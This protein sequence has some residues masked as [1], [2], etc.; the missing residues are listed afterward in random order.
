MVKYLWMRC[1]LQMLSHFCEEMCQNIFEYIV[2]RQFNIHPLFAYS[3]MVIH[4]HGDI[5]RISR[6]TT[7]IT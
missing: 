4:P 3:F 1:F 6:I 2:G 5:M 7:G